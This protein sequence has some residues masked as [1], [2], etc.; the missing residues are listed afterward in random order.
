MFDEP[1]RRLGHLEHANEERDGRDQADGKHVA[2]DALVMT[3]GVRDDRVDEEGE[4]LAND[5]GELV[6][7]AEG[8]STLGRGQLGQIDRDSRGRGTDAEAQ[9]KATHQQEAEVGGEH[10]AQRTEE[11]DDRD[12]RHRLLAPHLLVQDAGHETANRGT[13]QEARGDHALGL[14]REA[15]VGLHRLQSAIDDARVIAEEKAAECRH[16]GD[17]VET[18]LVG[19]RGQR[20]QVDLLDLLL[21]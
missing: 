6:A 11:E 21:R 9:H 12:H 20:W 3:P 5:D 1:A 19:S 4:E 14:G 13:D 15:E 10:T 7:S 16:H 17:Q 8:T 2:P 18:T